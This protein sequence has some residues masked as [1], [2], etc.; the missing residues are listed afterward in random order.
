MAITLKERLNIGDATANPW[1]G[2]G[3]QLDKKP[4][5]KDIAGGGYTGL[6]FIKPVV[7]K[8]LGQYFSLTTENTQNG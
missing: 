2:I 8:T 4:F 3:S 5:E 7:P 6:P 1:G